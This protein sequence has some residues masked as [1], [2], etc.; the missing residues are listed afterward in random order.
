MYYYLNP[1]KQVCGPY[2]AAELQSLLAAGTVT[3]ATL[4]A[5]E[6]NPAWQPLGTLNLETAQESPIGSCPFCGHEICAD[7]T[8]AHC[9]YCGES[10]HAGSSGLWRNF[11]YALKR[12]ATFRGRATRTEFW[13]FFLFNWLFSMVGG[14]F[15]ELVFLVPML[16]VSVRR[17]HD[18][19]RNAAAVVVLTAAGLAFIGILAYGIAVYEHGVIEDILPYVLVS[20]GM[21]GIAAVYLLVCAVLPSAPGPNQYGPSALYPHGKTDA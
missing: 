6:G 12:F 14:I 20:G 7:S 21:Y 4:A 10:L 5:K 9:P 11:V 13:S 17:L 2:T 8:P 16:A 15:A 1:E 18:T 19:G 3:P